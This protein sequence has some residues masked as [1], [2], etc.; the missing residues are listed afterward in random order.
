MLIVDDDPDFRALF[1]GSAPPD[2]ETVTCES[3][4]EA[5]ALLE[6]DAGVGI[7]FAVIDLHLGAFLDP[8]P[9]GEGLALARWMHATKRAV[10]TVLV[11]SDPRLRRR[12]VERELGL[13][14]F[15]GKPLRLDSL[16]R[17]VRAYADLFAD[18]KEEE[19]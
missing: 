7:A 19:T 11:S 6:S 8:R 15:L 1:A 5:L 17:L 18:T 4:R 14:G 13:L 2:V 10:P 16:Y 9:E 3:S 12:D